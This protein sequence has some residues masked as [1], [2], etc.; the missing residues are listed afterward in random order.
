M[1]LTTDITTWR[2]LVVDDEG[3]N[4]NLI[5]DL[6]EFS[7]ATTSRAKDGLEGLASVDTFQPNVILLDLGMPSMDGWE[8]QRQLRLRPELARVPIVALT[9]LAMPGDA[10]RVRAAGFDA[11][12][13]KPFRVKAI[14]ADLKDSVSS[15]IAADPANA[16]Q[17][18]QSEF[19]EQSQS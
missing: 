2:V 19:P 8:V 3:D 11:Y 14:L 16:A 9:A 12:I 18:P 15:F 4:L 5:S 6:L 1:E 10:E 13:T 17:T 7:G